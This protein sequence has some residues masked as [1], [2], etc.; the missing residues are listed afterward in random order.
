[1][2]IDIRKEANKYH[3]A[4]AA[5]TV[6]PVTGGTASAM[7]TTTDTEMWQK[8]LGHP[9]EEITKAGR[10]N[11]ALGVDFTTVV[12][13]WGTYRVATTEP[14]ENSRPQDNRITV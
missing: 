14:P 13:P 9:S 5:S 11:E 2:E 6:L 3:R 12:P 7:W 1:M 8:R 4:A 10:A